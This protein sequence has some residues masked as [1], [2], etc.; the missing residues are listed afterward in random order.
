MKRM[1]FGLLVIALVAALM[2]QPAQAGTELEPVGQPESKRIGYGAADY[3]INSS[4]TQTV[5]YLVMQP[6]Q[7]YGVDFLKV[8]RCFTI[9]VLLPYDCTI[10]LLQKNITYAEETWLHSMRWEPGYNS[11]L[12]TTADN[13]LKRWIHIQ[14]VPSSQRCYPLGT[15]GCPPDGSGYPPPLRSDPTPK[16]QD[17]DMA[18]FPLPAYCLKK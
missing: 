6:Y 3:W 14:F 11:V 10:Y 5:A 1:I 18:V 4:F 15:I 8:K 16:P 9:F 12:F 7:E 17:C 13:D 2:P